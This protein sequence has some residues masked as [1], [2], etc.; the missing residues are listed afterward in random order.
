MRS[1]FTVR[2]GHLY[3]KSFFCRGTHD[4]SNAI[5]PNNVIFGTISAHFVHFGHFNYC[6]LY[7]LYSAKYVPFVH[8]LHAQRS[9]SR[10]YVQY[11]AEQNLHIPYAI[12]TASS[13]TVTVMRTSYT[14]QSVHDLC[15]FCTLTVLNAIQLFTVRS[16]S[17]LFSKY[18]VSLLALYN[19]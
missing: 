10:F 6:S 8:T 17:N 5:F 2:N 9:Q 18:S 7:Y 16:K 15:I 14:M 13:S 12:F 3:R 19:T 11:Q 1:T 4:R